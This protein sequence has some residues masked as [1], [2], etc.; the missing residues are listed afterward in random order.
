MRSVVSRII[1]SV[2]MARFNTEVKAIFG[3]SFSRQQL[4]SGL[5]RLHAALIAQV[6]VVPAGE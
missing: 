5:L 2:R 1:Q 3:S 4:A 6:D